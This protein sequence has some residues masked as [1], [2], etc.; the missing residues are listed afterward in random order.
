MRII[1]LLVLAALPAV[2]AFAQPV[3]FT[4]APKIDVPEILT[5]MSTF[6]APCVQ[7]TAGQTVF[8]LCYDWH[9]SVHAHWAAFRLGRAE[10]SLNAIAETSYHALTPPKLAYEATH[11]PSF[12]MPYGYAW[13]LALAVEY[14]KWA[15]ERAKPDPQRLRILGDPVAAALLLNY[16]QIPPGPLGG[17][18]SNASWALAQLWEYLEMVG[19]TT[20]LLHVRTWVRQRFEKSWPQLSWS[21]D[22][23]SFAFFSRYGNWA[24]LLTRASSDETMRWFDV[25]HPV[26]P[27]DLAVNPLP[28]VH[29]FGLGWSRAW[30]MKALA[31]RAPYPGDKAQWL[32]AWAE[33][34]HVGMERHE[35]LKG[36]FLNYD[37]WVPQFAI[38][39]VTEGFDD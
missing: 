31:D 1:S 34:V 20:E 13:S 10:P 17:D 23:P 33:H 6:V 11:I 16:Q 29:S 26:L 25:T 21:D 36:S 22:L 28:S 30:A 32:D 7:P 8:T 19:A 14:E 9:S 27:G 35:T 38:Y 2:D 12:E 39:A 4:P 15:R 18:Y 37:H 5:E 3:Q 24:Y